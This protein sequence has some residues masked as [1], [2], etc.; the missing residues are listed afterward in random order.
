MYVYGKKKWK[1]NIL[2]EM[3]CDL[4][5][6]ISNLRIFTCA[7]VY[8]LGGACALW[9]SSTACLYCYLSLFND[10]TQNDL[11]LG[12]FSTCALLLFSNWRKS[13]PKIRIRFFSIISLDFY[14]FHG[15]VFFGS[16]SKNQIEMKK[17]LK[18]QSSIDSSFTT[19]VCKCPPTMMKHIHVHIYIHICIRCWKCTCVCASSVSLPK[20]N[21]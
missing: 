17:T 3:A 8:L 10:F 18:I 5:N 4:N 20:Q 11:L 21:E 19:I 16:G 6:L 9:Y 14:L 1:N 15:V 13:L 2:I 7:S 12:R